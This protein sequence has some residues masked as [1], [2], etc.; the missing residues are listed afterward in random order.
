MR[1]APPPAPAPAAPAPPRASDRWPTSGI[2][3]LVLLL[4]LAAYWPA[5][6]GDFLWDDAGHVTSPGL[7]NAAGLL[8]IW[9]EPGTTQQYYPLL[10]SAFW[11]EHQ[12]WGDAP[13]GYHLVNLLWHATAATLFVLL[14]RRLALRGALLAG[15]VFALHPVGVESVAWI[16]EQKNTLSLVL[17]L[18]AALAWL[19]YEEDRRPGRYAAATAWFIA[20]LLT[21]TVTATLPPALLVLAWWRRGRLAW[22]T[23][24]VPLLPWLGLGLLAGL[25]TA[26]LESTQIGATGNDFS[27]GPLERM[28]LAG[29]IVWFY[30][31]KL[32]WPAD[33]TFFYPRWSVD[34]T[35]AWQ[36]LFTTAALGLLAV[37]AAWRHRQRGPLAA[38]LL[39]G[40]ILFP[41][42][43]FVNVYPFIFSY[44]ADHF[45][46]HASLAPIA[47]LT[48]AAVHAWD[49][50]P[51]PR[52]LALLASALLLAGLGTLTWRQ[53]TTYRDVFSL[54]QATL[55]R[56]PDSWVA[57]LNLGTALD[58]AGRPDEALP[59][60]QRANTLKPDFPETLNTLAN[61]LS[62][63]GRAAE[64]LPLIERA[65]QLQPRFAAAHNTRGVV[66]MA[67]SRPADGTA[68]FRRALELD[69]A[70][71]LA[72]VNLAWALANAGQPA[73][74]LRQLDQ[75]RRLDPADAGIEHKTAL[76]HAMAGRPDLAEPHARRAV[77]LQPGDPDL[78]CLHGLLLLQ[79]GRPAES[80]AAFDTALRLAPGH[81]N[82]LQGLQEAS[83]RLG[84]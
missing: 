50:R 57:H 53:S 6:H 46:Y 8:R 74:A 62:R 38:A 30:A 42:L 1:S 21:K 39:Y 16:A 59:H 54:Y 67:L 14:L 64:A 56:N 7:Q 83:R 3:S 72:R 10:H 48:S 69:P 5:L 33:L 32:L 34:A 66:L 24:A 15:L 43:G 22:R 71:T 37:A 41:V 20:A 55:A 44:V 65:G 68:A 9:F 51:R 26:W 12:L 29:R 81:P 13:L 28:L 31:G 35:A 52:G 19:R 11:L 60:L 27:L 47:F 45:Q 61:V 4:V 63:L 76:V 77:A 25:S 40:G 82:A 23:D 17:A 84:R 73:E 36:W 18:A 49:R 58:D 78:L 79:L 2:F 70:L 75:A 80:A